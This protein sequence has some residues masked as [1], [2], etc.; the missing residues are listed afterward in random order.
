LNADSTKKKSQKEKKEKKLTFKL[1]NFCCLN[2]N[3]ST[4]IK[5]N[6][7]GTPIIEDSGT[8]FTSIIIADKAPVRA[9]TEINLKCE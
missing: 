2:W 1:N 4:K 9:K 8:E 3:S 5:I 6:E 7:K